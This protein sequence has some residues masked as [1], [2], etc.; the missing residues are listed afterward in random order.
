MFHPLLC[1]QGIG[2]FSCIKGRQTEESPK[3][4]L[5]FWGGGGTPAKHEAVKRCLE[6]NLQGYKSFLQ[7]VKMTEQE[8]NYRVETQR[9][10]QEDKS[11]VEHTHAGNGCWLEM[12]ART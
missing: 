8:L 1:P 3:P 2:Y 9:T 10:R 12:A 4:D 11:Q 6:A 5:F 7:P